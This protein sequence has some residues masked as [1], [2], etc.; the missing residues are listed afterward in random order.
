M[1]PEDELLHQIIGAGKGATDLAHLFGWR[2]A[3]FRPAQTAKGWRTAVAGDGSG[4]P[5]L[6]LT[7][8]PRHIIAELKSETGEIRADQK[9]W[10]EVLAGCPNLEVYVWR[11]PDLETIARIMGG[12]VPSRA[13]RLKWLR[14]EG[15]EV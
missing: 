4:W 1:K 2:S 10:L 8:P 15:L 6:T 13:K 14:A 3:H 12:W 11:P 5:D 9:V 7:K